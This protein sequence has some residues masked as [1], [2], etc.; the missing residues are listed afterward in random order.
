MICLIES[1]H[2]RAEFFAYS[3]TDL[4]LS[5]TGKTRRSVLNRTRGVCVPLEINV[6]G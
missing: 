2:F 3:L 1:L 5:V 4:I 6:L